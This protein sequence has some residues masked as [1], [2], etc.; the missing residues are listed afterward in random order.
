MPILAVFVLTVLAT[1]VW[2]LHLPPSLPEVPGI[3]IVIGGWIL[4]ATLRRNIEE[5]QLKALA[6]TLHTLRG[7]LAAVS[8]TRAAE[9]AG[10]LEQL[11][12]QGDLPAI[13]SARWKLEAELDVLRGTLMAHTSSSA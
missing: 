12:H 9:L 4:L 10:V 13:E 11:A 8:A 1:A 2:I 6:M 5:N 3:L 7:A